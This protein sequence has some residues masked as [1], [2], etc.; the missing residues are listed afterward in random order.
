[1][2]MTIMQ[3][4]RFKA[5]TILNLD[6]VK[7]FKERLF[8]KN[9]SELMRSGSE[10]LNPVS[11]CRKNEQ[12]QIIV[13]VRTIVE[14]FFNLFEKEELFN[15]DTYISTLY[16]LL[17]EITKE[18]DEYFFESDI[19]VA[20]KDIY[21]ADTKTTIELLTKNIIITYFNHVK[22]EPEPDAE[23]FV[24]LDPQL[25]A[26]IKISNSGRDY[27]SLVER[28]LKKLV[29]IL[30]HD[31]TWRKCLLY[32]NRAS[33]VCRLVGTKLPQIDKKVLASYIQQSRVEIN[34]EAVL[35]SKIINTREMLIK[36]EANLKNFLKTMEKLRVALNSVIGKMNNY[37]FYAKSFMLTL[38]ASSDV[39]LG[40]IDAELKENLARVILNY[41]VEDS[42]S[43]LQL[44]YASLRYRINRLLAQ[45]DLTFYFKEIQNQETY[46]LCYLNIFKV[47]YDRLLSLMVK[48]AET[49]LE[50][51][52]KR[53]DNVLF[54]CKKVIKN[55]S[56]D[57]H[58]F[59]D[60]KF[61]IRKAYVE[62]LKVVSVEQTDEL[63]DLALTV[64]SVTQDKSGEFFE[65]VRKVLLSDSFTA[66]RHIDIKSIKPDEI[67][68]TIQ[69]TLY[70]YSIHYRPRR[71]FY[72]T[73]FKTY[74][75][76]KN[77]P[78]SVFIK[79]LITTNQPLALAILKVLSEKDAVMNPL[80][81][82]SREYASDLMG[83]IK[84][85]KTAN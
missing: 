73:F 58:L 19:S 75:G 74:I 71:E 24:L 37:F 81:E 53:L 54:E 63:I 59:E 67:K 32:M 49:P 56:L 61:E 39:F 8:Q 43:Y 22:I 70:G 25:Q 2:P 15:P 44:N 38:G 60:E 48:M 69:K 62:L 18:S 31:N 5:M 4:M 55:L 29:E 50:M 77:K 66:L 13:P 14:F 27:R 40:E 35:F 83:T 82:S 17:K 21:E 65:V 42:E 34:K 47:Y 68:K 11:M 26:I 12:G 79:E 72:N 41:S 76:A 28:T 45:S 16:Y 85:P 20:E 23:D 78:P 7:K 9:I 84:K 51:D 57:I 36:E 80:P 6:D 10:G 64:V 46:K 33:L 3:F 1:M 52:I 30:N